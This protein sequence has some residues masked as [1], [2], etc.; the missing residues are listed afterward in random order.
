MLRLAITFLA[1]AVLA[2]PV[3]ARQASEPG[4]ELTVYLA[5]IHPGDAVWEKFGHNAIWIRDRTTGTT[6]AYDYGRF[7]FSEGFWPRFLRGHMEYSMGVDDADLMLSWYAQ[8]NRT[9]SVQLLNLTPAQRH[10]LREFLEWNWLPQ[11]RLYRYDYFRDNCSTRVRDALDLALGGRLRAALVGKPTGTTFRSHSLRLTAA[12]PAVFTGLIIGLGM[13]TDVPIDAWEETFI[14][15]ELE[16]HLRS[17]DLIGEDGAAVPLVAEETVAFQANRAP[18]PDSAPDRFLIYLVAGLGVAGL[19]I[20][21][22]WRARSR[23]LARHGLGLAIFFWAF[24]TGFFGL[25]LTLLWL[26]TD[27]TAAYPNQNVLQT[28]PLGLLLAVAAPLALGARRSG[29]ARLARP[30]AVTILALSLIGVI[31]HAVPSLYQM[32]G[33]LIALVLPVHAAVVLALYQVGGRGTSPAEDA[34]SRT[35]AP[36]VA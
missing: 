12:F 25:I 18:P 19:L 13:P 34:V 36:A 30:L 3:V 9:V 1:S 32:N 8:N 20:V 26:L 35:A 16:R 17:V 15:M 28:N 6:I 27:H 7:E 10:S 29:L 11:N 24:A 2:A 33:P 14:P 4:A 31:L 21:L 23:R 22:A 5:T